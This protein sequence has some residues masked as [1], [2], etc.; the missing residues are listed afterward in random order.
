MSYILELLGR[1]VDSDLSDLLDRYFWSS[2]GEGEQSAAPAKAQHDSP[3]RRLQVGLAHL[4]AGRLDEAVRH[5]DDACRAKGDCLSARA[6]LASACDEKGDPAGAL[7]HLKVADEIRPSEAAVLFGIAFCLE[8]LLEPEK[9]AAYYRRAVAADGSFMTARERLAA[10]GVLTGELDEAIEQYQ[11][12]RDLEPREICYRSALAHLYLRSRRHDEAVDEFETAIALEPDNWALVDD[13]VEAMVAEG[14]IRE[15]VERLHWLISQQGPFADLHVRLGDLCSRVR[16]DDGAVKNYLLAL[17]LQPGYLEA[18]VKLGTHHLVNGRWEEAAEAFHRAAELNDRLLTCYVGMGVAQSAL[19]EGDAAGNSFD[20]AGAVEPNSTMLMAE[21]ARLQLRSAASGDFPAGFPGG[22]EA[23]AEGLDP[24]GDELLRRQIRRHA[25]EVHRHPRHADL[26]YRYG[27]LL[28]AQQQDAAA[29]EQFN[30]AARLSPS[31]TKAWIK[32]GVVRQELGLGDEAIDAFCRA[33]DI[34]P[35][36]VELH[37]RLALLYTNREKFENEVR[38]MEAEA[39]ESERDRIRADL[40]L[41]LQNMAL[42]D[43]VSATWRSLW[44]IHRARAG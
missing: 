37:Y 7:E 31:Y 1:G 2:S 12:L 30:E 42:M 5:L 19:G 21:V 13:D 11:S 18:T 20:L 9:A 3:Q 41:S 14:R 28:R 44:K 34:E 32:L 35:R 15:A 26:R 16:D 22:A 39:G 4:R 27:V 33:L 8:K 24:A 38:R 25:E 29:M 23:P 10:I 43:R 6:A 40:A 36:L 17:E